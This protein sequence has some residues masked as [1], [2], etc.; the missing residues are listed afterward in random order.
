[1][2]EC[3]EE[4][5]KQD[6]V[7]GCEP[8]EWLQEFNRWTERFFSPKPTI[9]QEIEAGLEFVDGEA[10]S[11]DNLAM[12]CTQI[13]LPATKYEELATQTPLCT[14]NDKT[15]W[16]PKNGGQIPIYSVERLDKIHYCT[17]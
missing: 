6:T 11:K 9:E 10:F 5:R 4:F 16:Y 13:Y 17:D 7:K 14:E 8:P 1:M 2:E 12:P 15:Y 3:L